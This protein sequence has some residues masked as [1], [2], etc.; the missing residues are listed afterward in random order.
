[1]PQRR[2]HPLGDAGQL[3]ARAPV[4][5]AVRPVAPPADY[6]AFLEAQYGTISD[7]VRFVGARSHLSRDMVDEL[8]SRV[9]LHLTVN[10]YAVLRQWRQEGSLH[11]Y[12]VTVITRVFLDYR[13]QEWGKAKPPA[14]ARRLGPVA[15]ML[16]RLTHRKRLT[17]DEAVSTLHAEHGVTLT[18]DELRTI[19][20][21]LPVASGRYFVDVSELEHR[22]HPGAEADASVRAE[23]RSLIAHRVERALAESLTGLS[24]EDRLI[25][26]L[27]FHDG[28]SRAEIARS[29]RLDQQRL[30]PRFL[31]LLTRL[32]TALLAQGVT[33]ADI[34][35]IIAVPDLDGGSSVIHEACKNPG[36]GPSHE[37]CQTP[38][39][40]IG[41]RL[42]ES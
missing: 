3:P 24:V 18:R 11:T 16:W 33:L 34:R 37:V 27:F 10:D 40:P 17:F 25:V 14:V 1:M 4:V 35:H 2:S 15:L 30:Y 39:P 29:L 5:A 42:R 19:F 8:K 9:L 20:T 12:L 21:Q 41:R 6:R 36:G 31:A 23:E 28:L 13:N 26:K 7:A 32:K 22:E 38:V